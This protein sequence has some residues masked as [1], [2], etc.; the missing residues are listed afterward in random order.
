MDSISWACK[1]TKYFLYNIENIKK[2]KNPTNE[3]IEKELQ[4]FEKEIEN[5]FSS[6]KELLEKK[7]LLLNKNNNKNNENNENKNIK[8][9]KKKKIITPNI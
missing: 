4:N 2:I 9:R 1:N 6:Q 7:D 5:I 8:K 3:Y